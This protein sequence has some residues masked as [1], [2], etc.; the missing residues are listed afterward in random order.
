MARFIAA[1]YMRKPISGSRKGG[2][3]SSIGRRFAWRASD[4]AHRL[5]PPS[6]HTRT[7]WRDAILRYAVALLATTA[8]LI[9]RGMLEPVLG[10][11]L[12]FTTLFAA[13]AVSVLVGG[14][15]PAALAMVAGYVAAEYLFVE[16]IGTVFVSVPPD[17]V[18]L[19]LYTVSCLI[20][21][22]FGG[23]MRSARRRLEREVAERKRLEEKLREADRR[24]D[25]FLATVA[26]E[27]KH[28]LA[29]IRNVVQVMQLKDL[30]DKELRWARGVIDRQVKH[31]ARLVDDLL[32]VSRIA[33]GKVELRREPLAV[34]GIVGEAV[35]LTRP[36]LEANRHELCIVLPP[37]AL[38]VEGDSTRLT[39]VVGNLLDNA[40]KYTPAG[41]HIMVSAE[42]DGDHVAIRVH[43]DGIGIPEQMLSRVFEPFTRSDQ[44]LARSAGGTGLGLSVVRTLVELHGG[45]VAVRSAGPGL[46]SEFRVRLPLCVTPQ[47]PIP[48]RT[49]PR[50][51][52]HAP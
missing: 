10:G 37:E 23:G 31:L 24:K 11:S 8:A 35:E 3:L 44:P 46:G 1:D 29:P 50:A 28:P 41:G 42:R 21:I 45:S 49:S 12:V 48:E 16:P 43:D 19:A 4:P 9:L 26:H 27:L 51:A 33:R 39:Q 38:C 52:A 25:L 13:V 32:D 40:A 20:I 17:P 47:A 7:A 2:A 34:S 36:L 18:R 6:T 30:P 22:G 5:V 14:Y 15:G